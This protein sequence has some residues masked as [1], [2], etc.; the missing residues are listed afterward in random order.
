MKLLILIFMLVSVHASELTTMQDACE[1]NISDA[2]YNLGAIYSGEDELKPQL[3]KSKYY[4][5]KACEL[6]NDAACEL[7][8]KVQEKF[9]HR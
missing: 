7:L 2:C 9:S 4:L 6:D 5:K 1:R 3:K 8:D